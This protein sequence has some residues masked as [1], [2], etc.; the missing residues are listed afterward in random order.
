L[1]ITQFD[2]HSWRIASFRCAAEFGRYRGMAGIGQARTNQPR[3]MS[4][5]PSWS[6]TKSVVSPKG[7]M[8]IRRRNPDTGK[9]EARRY[10]MTGR[11]YAEEWQ[12]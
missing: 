4:T 9:I 2:D 7:E 3:V 8:T 10:R 5:R 1:I 6:K 12:K 11:G